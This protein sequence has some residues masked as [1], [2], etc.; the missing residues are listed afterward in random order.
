M[1]GDCF[2]FLLSNIIIQLDKYK[3]TGKILASQQMSR[4]VYVSTKQQKYMG[5]VQLQQCF[6]CTKTS[7]F[8]FTIGASSIKTMRFSK[9]P[10]TTIPRQEAPKSLT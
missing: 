5:P 8:C 7:S 1:I 3:S 6:I 10:R 2:Q 9:S 4:T